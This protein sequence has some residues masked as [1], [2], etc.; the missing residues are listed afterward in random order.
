MILHSNILMIINF[1]YF[2]IN[3]YKRYLEHIINF[4]DVIINCHQF[5]SS[6]SFDKARLLNNET[7]LIDSIINNGDSFTNPTFKDIDGNYIFP[8]FQI[9]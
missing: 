4:H 5:E 9:L 8:G 2:I 1:L 3:L 7:F 6:Y